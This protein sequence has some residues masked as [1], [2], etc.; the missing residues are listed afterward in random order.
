MEIIDNFDDSILDDFEITFA[1]NSV[2]VYDVNKKPLYYEPNTYS[3]NIPFDEFES[4][5]NNKTINDIEKEFNIKLPYTIKE[6]DSEILLDKLEIFK[7]QDVQ[8]YDFKNMINSGLVSDLIKNNKKFIYPINISDNNIF[9]E[10]IN[11]T[12]E[13]V[14]YIKNGN[15]KIVFFYFM[16]GHFGDIVNHYKWVSDLSYKYGLD[17]NNNI[18]VNGNLISGDIYNK[19]I[20]SDVID[21]NFS[22]YPF[23]WFE[24]CVLFTP[25]GSQKMQKEIREQY[26]KS[27]SNHI[28][29]NRENRKR[30]HFSSLN[31]LPKP[32]RLCIFYELKTNDAFLDKSILSLGGVNTLYDYDGE[33]TFH[34]VV[35][36]FLSENYKYD[37][38]KM[39]NFYKKYNQ[40]ENYIYDCEDLNNN[41]AE[42]FNTEVHLNSFVNIVTE[43]LFNNY[44]VFFSEKIYKPIYSCQPFI[45]FGNPFSLKKL[46]DQGYR[47]FNKWWDESYDLETDFTKRLEKIVDVMLEIST[48]DSEKYF[49]VTNEMEEILIHNFKILMNDD[50]TIK[51]YEFLSNK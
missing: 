33:L 36:E 11:L 18:I 43:S 4:V 13:L 9:N 40:F 42:S 19:L 25:D 28:S 49:N 35:N 39:I 50:E 10:T 34:G 51:L 48:W 1:Y 31:R 14:D 2:L 7:S 38:Q 22:V 21:D 20:E 29:N 30:Y 26:Y 12:Q 24:Y 47:T 41:K 32:H 44:S 46:K 37:K 45:L 27:L 16:E 23:S 15:A 5:Y 6:D 3:I 17:K 8:L